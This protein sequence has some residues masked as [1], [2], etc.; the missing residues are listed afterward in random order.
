MSKSSSFHLCCLSPPLPR[1]DMGPPLDN[2]PS[3]AGSEGL[4]SVLGLVK[5]EVEVGAGLGLLPEPGLDPDS[6]LEVASM[7]LE[8]EVCTGLVG[9][10]VGLVN[11]GT[12][13]GPLPTS[14]FLFKEPEVG[15]SGFLDPDTDCFSG[16]LAVDCKGCLLV[17]L[18]IL[19]L[20]LKCSSVNFVDGQFKMFE[21]KY[22]GHSA[23][24]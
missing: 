18:L 13:T 21:H 15:I 14:G 8:A 5:L 20:N 11:P 1:P 6:G 4:L 10:E 17:I 24:V 3:E 19:V 12:L 9:T 23:P 7:G 2:V 16:R 22:R